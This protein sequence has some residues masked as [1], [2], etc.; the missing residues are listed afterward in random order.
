MSMPQFPALPPGY[1]INDSIAQV[2]TSVALEEIGL[3]HII[4]A[5]G[6]KIQYF[7]GTLEGVPA[8]QVPAT[9]EQVLEL[10]ESVK[11]MLSQVSFSQMFLMGK[12]QA[13][14]NAYQSNPTPPV[15]PSGESILVAGGV[16]QSQQAVDVISMPVAFSQ[17][18]LQV[19]N[20]VSLATGDTG[21]M[22]NTSGNY[23]ID[24]QLSVSDPNTPT[25]DLFLIAELHSAVQNALQ[26]M[27]ITEAYVLQ[28]NS[29]Q[30][31]LTAG[32]VISLI[33]RRQNPGNFF[34]Y[35]P[36]ITFVKLP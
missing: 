4:N 36:V 34:V 12:M 27:I 33:V 16:G 7:L 17:P 8:P 24:Y 2:V 32:D 30:V 23:Q 25:A 1:T 26:T 35:N 11:D 21:F 15:P 9:F 6:E 13:A 22:I 14:L 29:I 20:D 19:G 3:S 31:V 18:V 28:Q 10:N 5:E